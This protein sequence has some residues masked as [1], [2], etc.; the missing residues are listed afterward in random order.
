M[1]YATTSLENKPMWL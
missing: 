1:F